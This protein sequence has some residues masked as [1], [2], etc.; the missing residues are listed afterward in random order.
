MPSARRVSIQRLLAEAT[1]V[2]NPY[3]FE[4]IFMLV[5]YVLVSIAVVIAFVAPMIL[6]VLHLAPRHE[7]S[8]P[9]LHRSY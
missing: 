7:A 2:R 6:K 5:P 8:V 1:R 3:K 9:A 4:A